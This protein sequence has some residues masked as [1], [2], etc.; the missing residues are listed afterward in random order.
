MTVLAIVGKADKRILAYPLMKTCGLMGKTCVVT[1]DAA[2][3]RLYPGTEDT[4]TVCDVEVT[5]KCPLDCGVAEAFVR[6]KEAESFDY[7][8]CLTEAFVPPDAKAVI[9]LCSQRRTFCGRELEGMIADEGER[10]FP[11]TLTVEP[12][13][14]NYWKA[15]LVQ[16]VWKADYIRY[17]CETEERRQLMPLGDRAVNRLLCDAFHRALHLERGSM[18]KIMDRKLA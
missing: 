11:A 5:V 18:R 7:L 10:F 3:R 16:L 15:S 12:K 4:G 13:P 6:R 8:L 2:Y 14:K 9:A 17:I 1:D